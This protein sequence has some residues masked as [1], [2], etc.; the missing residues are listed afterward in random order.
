MVMWGS[1]QLL[2]AVTALACEQLYQASYSAANQGRCNAFR[3]VTLCKESMQVEISKLGVHLLPPPKGQPQT[4]LGKSFVKFLDTFGKRIIFS[5]VA[6]NKAFE[7]L[8]VASEEGQVAAEYQLRLLLRGRRVALSEKTPRSPSTRISPRCL[9]VS[10]RVL[11]FLPTEEPTTTAKEQM[12]D[13]V[14]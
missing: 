3:A 1:L 6:S 4:L 5:P 14:F 9:P 7:K 12:S 10:I 2:Y 8:L 11:Y 13:G